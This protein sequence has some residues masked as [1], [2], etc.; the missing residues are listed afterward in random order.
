MFPHVLHQLS[1]LDA[2]SSQPTMRFE[3]VAAADARA[4]SAAAAAADSDGGGEAW[5][6]IT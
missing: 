1:W 6:F 5:F 4:A 2:S 3:E